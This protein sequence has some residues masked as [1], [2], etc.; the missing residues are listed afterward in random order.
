MG[1]IDELFGAVVFC[2][3]AGRAAWR[4]ESSLFGEVVNVTWP[5][6]WWC[7][8]VPLNGRSPWLPE[9]AA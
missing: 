8:S 5:D 2:A 4:R 3:T 9:R 6:G 1:E 7:L